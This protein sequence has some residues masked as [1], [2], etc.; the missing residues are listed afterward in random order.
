MRLCDLFIG[1]IDLGL[2]GRNLRLE[3][4]D[5][6]LRLIALRDVIAIVEA[7]KLGA[8]LDFLVI[9]HRH[10]DDGGGDL[11]ADLH[12]AGIDEGIVGRFV[13]PRMQPPQHD[14]QDDDGAGDD[15]GQNQAPPFAQLG[16]ER[17]LLFRRDGGGSWAG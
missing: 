9:G 1:L 17:G 5:I 6:G 16:E 11:G 15:D 3:I 4:V 12:R 10:V 8:G 14:R 7:G 2:L 13:V